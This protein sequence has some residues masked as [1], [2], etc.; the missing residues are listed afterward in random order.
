MYYIIKHADYPWK[1]IILSIRKNIM[2]Y[3]NT[4]LSTKLTF[5]LRY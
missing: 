3:Q 2:I 1:L 4:K 5:N